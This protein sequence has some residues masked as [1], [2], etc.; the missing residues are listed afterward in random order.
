M[1]GVCVCV[2][3][4]VRVRV[5]VCMPVCVYPLDYKQ[6]VVGCGMITDMNHIWLAKQVTQ[7]LYGSYNSY[8]Q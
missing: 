6:R 3:V 1:S 8:T 7:C 2:C 5:C 4:C